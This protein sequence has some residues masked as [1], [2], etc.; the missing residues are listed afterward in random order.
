MVSVVSDSREL[1]EFKKQ[2]KGY[3][4]ALGAFRAVILDLSNQE[5]LPYRDL[6]TI[7]K[8][9]YELMSHDKEVW[10]QIGYQ[11]SKA[12]DDR[13]VDNRGQQL[14]KSHTSYL[15]RAVVLY[16]IQHPEND[17]LARTGLENF[18][19][20]EFKKL[21]LLGKAEVLADMLER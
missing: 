4:Y 8:A 6:Y 3:S 19:E 18:M 21:S 16:L 9:A 15:V 10:S 20:D 17:S 1:D 7:T 13:A 11:V 14:V 5:S 2:N 12:L